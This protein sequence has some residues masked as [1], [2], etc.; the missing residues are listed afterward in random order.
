MQEFTTFLVMCQNQLPSLVGDYIFGWDE[1]LSPK[2]HI[3]VML[4]LP[5]AMLKKMSTL[6]ILRHS[7]DRIHLNILT[8]TLLLSQKIFNRQFRR[9]WQLRTIQHTILRIPHSL[10]HHRL[11]HKPLFQNVVW[12][13]LKFHTLNIHFHVH[14]NQ[15]H[16]ISQSL[17]SLELF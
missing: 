2:M 8:F 4:L 7:P 3:I 9:L 16:L 17:F 1:Y 12:T 6:I 14:I 11:R 15:L 13:L 5:I 10:I